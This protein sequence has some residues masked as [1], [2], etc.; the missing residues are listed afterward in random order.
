MDS[1]TPIG[2][3]PSCGRK[4]P[5]GILWC[6]CSYDYRVARQVS[7]AKPTLTGMKWKDIGRCRW[8]DGDGMIRKF[9]NYPLAV[10]GLVSVFVALKAWMMTSDRLSPSANPG[11]ALGSFIVVCL[12]AGLFYYSVVQSLSSYDIST[13]RHKKSD[14]IVG[15]L[16]LSVFLCA[17][18]VIPLY[19]WYKR[20]ERRYVAEQVGLASQ[21]EDT[22]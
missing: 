16:V 13:W 3:C 15:F 10:F 8:R 2:Q 9:R 6:P 7:T 17:L 4:R 19:W 20:K 21:A 12:I 1:N 18:P 14:K 11:Y 5:E 22:Q